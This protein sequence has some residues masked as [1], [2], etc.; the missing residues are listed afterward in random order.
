MAYVIGL[1]IV[2]ILG[3]CVYFNPNIYEFFGIRYENAQS[4]IMQ[5]NIAYI[6]GK[7]EYLT[8]L[9][10]EYSKET[11]PTV[12]TALKNTYIQELSTVDNKKLPLNLLN[13]EN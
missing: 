9:K 8:R 3:L 11:D 2:V 5:N 1:L 7:I 12:K 6:R 10:L 13:I 4:N